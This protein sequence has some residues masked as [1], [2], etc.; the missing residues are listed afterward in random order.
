MTFTGD[1]IRR[2]E[3]AATKYRLSVP[4]VGDVNRDGKSELIFGTEAGEIYCVSG[5]G[6][7]LR[8]LFMLTN[9]A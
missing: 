7:F 4:A 5:Q 8:E 3:I 9:S 2:L 6:D 1:A